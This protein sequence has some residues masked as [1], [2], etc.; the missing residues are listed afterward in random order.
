[1]RRF[2]LAILLFVTFASVLADDSE[3]TVVVAT[4]FLE[5]HTGPADVYP[6]TQV[7]ER[8][9]QVVVLKQRTGWFKVRGP[10]GN[11]G[12]VAADKLTE[13]IR[14]PAD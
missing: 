10:R 11:E 6:V 7:I 3:Q 2:W 5:I 4:P 12:W 14:A 13:A 8:G 1:M 9:D